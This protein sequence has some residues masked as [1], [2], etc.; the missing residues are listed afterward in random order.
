MIDA[1]A[2][3]FAALDATERRR[4]SGVALCMALYC[5]H[6]VWFST[7]LIEDAA[8][9]YAFADHFAS[10]EGFVAY[11]GGE[12]VEGFS[13]PT[14]TLLLSLTAWL[15][16]P[17]WTMGKLLGV[18][19]GL[20][21]IPL[22]YL[23]ARR[24]APE[25]PGNWALIA[26]LAVAM[27]TQHTLWAAAG[28]E[29][30]LFNLLLVAAVVRILHEGDAPRWG[31]SGLLL[32][33]LAI[34]RPE[35]PMYA[36]VIALFGAVGAMKAGGKRWV[37]SFLVAGLS[38]FLGWHAWR[39]WTFAWELPN[40][41]YA[42]Q[43]D[44][45]FQ[46]FAWGKRG[47]HYVRN[48][49]LVSVHGFMLPVFTLGQSGVHGKLGWVGIAA[50]SL[51]IG[52]L[53]TGVGWIRTYGPI[54]LPP[55]PLFVIQLRV[56][57]LVLAAVGFPLLGILR[58]H[59]RPRILA[60]VLTLCALFFAIYTGGD[61][62]RG[63]RWLSMAAIPLAVLLADAARE[64]AHAVQPAVVAAIRRP[65][66]HGVVA[67]LF[68]IP[69][70]GGGL[71]QTVAFMWGLETTPFD[72]RRRVLY[73]QG[74]QK[75]LHLDHASLLEVDMGAHMYWS[76]F[77]LVDMAGLVDVPIAHHHYERH[78]VD[79][80]V[81]EE[82]NP[83][84]A[85]VHAG[86]ANRTKINRRPWFHPNYIEI[87]GFGN[88][89]AALHVG[90]H[91]RK[92]LF[93]QKEWTGEP[94]RRVAFGEVL[95]EGL[96]VPAPLVHPGGGLYV[97]LG[98]GMKKRPKGFRPL[99][100]LSNGDRVVVK[101]LPPAYDWWPVARWRRDQ[102]VI[103]RHTL[104]LP[105]DLE[106]GSYD[107]GIALIPDGPR[108]RIYTGVPIDADGQPEPARIP[109]EPHYM[110]GEARFIGAVQVAPREAV[111]ARAS[112]TLNQALDRAGQDDC[113]AAEAVWA[114]S[115]RYLRPEDPWHD[116]ADPRLH[117]ALAICWAH[118]AAST[119]D[120]S[121]MA[122]ARRYDHRAPEVVS[123]GG[124]LADRWEAA[125]DI[126]AASGDEPA[127]LRGWLDALIADP[128]RSWVRRRAEKL[129]S[130]MLEQEDL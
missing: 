33:L 6:A 56:T 75:R 76:G 39:Y 16:L 25:D 113:E 82:R 49:A 103:G 59:A 5:F 30:G 101:E 42:K 15:G 89:F 72:V 8:I 31:V 96:D 27:S 63:Y 50:T 40:T 22:S 45:K 94:G 77:D 9:S 100:F 62:M 117:R 90:N 68:A 124:Q 119:D 3:R 121:A 1:L 67:L 70:L 54:D 71:G 107:L 102:V 95:L 29:N 83:T 98:W 115:R 17:P 37:G 51:V 2:D 32:G 86:W 80:Y 35:A 52:I 7:W 125:A 66:S 58:P 26:P 24:T 43:T 109:A 129:R 116:G 84:F 11:P 99:L 57:V 91:V 78:F 74:V 65:V 12:P 92:D 13:N 106:P 108:R 120:P 114:E 41:Y 112:D 123:I 118:I 55:E 28:L 85:H 14:W 130:R 69:I 18:G 105:E 19:F 53:S 79:A 4:W 60:W 46:P 73:M 104:S 38:P 87:P 34:T 21:A 111:L 127:A 10:G 126:F 48:W 20:L 81:H 64:L 128:S 44:E 110:A 97:E 122:T 88:S 23:W 36:G 93:I 61:W 47:W